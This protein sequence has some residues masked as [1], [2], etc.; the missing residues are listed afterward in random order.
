MIF[1]PHQVEITVAGIVPE[2]FWAFYTRIGTFSD[3]RDVAEPPALVRAPRHGQRFEA[4]VGRALALE[5]PGGKGRL[6]GEVGGED[7]GREDAEKV[8]GGGPGG[9]GDGHGFSP[10]SLPSRGRSAA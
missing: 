8:R 9:C 2:G 10:R 3:P 5:P 1:S 4:G 6:G 7:L